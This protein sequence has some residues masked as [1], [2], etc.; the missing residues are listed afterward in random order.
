MIL[1]H[2]RQ[3]LSNDKLLWRLGIVIIEAGE[4][5]WCFRDEIGKKERR[6]Y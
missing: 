3:V 6:Y 1:Q 4:G 5:I 2:A